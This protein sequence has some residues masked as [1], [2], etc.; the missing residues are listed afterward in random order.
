MNLK[1][2]KTALIIGA[3]SGLGRALSLQLAAKGVRVFAVAR[4]EER[5]HT[6]QLEAKTKNLII[7]IL[8]A[9]I[10]EKN[11]IRSIYHAAVGVLDHIDLLINCA[12]TLGVEKLKLLNDTECEE[13]EEALQTNL[14]GPFRLTKLVSAQMSLRQSGLVI[15]IT[16]D[17]SVNPYPT[18]GAYSVSK[19][20]L[21]HLS[22][23]Y[24]QELQEEGVQF[25][26][27]DPGDMATPLH[28]QAVPEANLEALKDPKISANQILDLLETTG[29][30]QD[31]RRVL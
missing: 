12:S 5:L 15:N 27:I 31:V 2:I 1:S 23:I 26:A 20:A 3:S 22:R 10:S 14:L 19:A 9:D 28:F 16:S 30:T 13:F 18:W 6:L 29:A 8:A 17:A 4:G 11:Q 21:D 24:E 25:L 7:E